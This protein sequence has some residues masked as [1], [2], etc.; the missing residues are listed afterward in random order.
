MTFEELRLAAPV[1]KALEREGYAEPTPIQTQA[2]PPLLDGRDILAIA[3][4]G[5]GKTAAFALPILHRLAVDPQAPPKRGCRALVLSP[6]RELAAQI[7]ESFRVYGRF[8]ELS[9]AVVVGGVD[10]RKQIKKLV[11]GVDVLVATPG[12]LIDH[13]EQGTVRLGDTQVFVLD[14]ADQMLDMGFVR[15]IRRIAGDLPKQRQNLFFSATM[16]KEIAGLA[17]ELLTDPVK[18][19][20]TP[21]ATTAER[22]EQRIIHVDAGRK[23][24]LLA[25]LFANPEMQRSL[26]FTRTKRGAD[27]V[28]KHLE[29]SGVSAAAIH[30]NK[31]QSQRTKALNAFRDASVRVLVATDI[32][33]RGIDID[34]VTHVVNYELPEVPEAYVHRIGRTARAGASG[35]AISLCDA[36][37]REL[38]RGIEKL[39][40]QSIPS[41]SRVG[42]DSLEVTSVPPRNPPG[43]GSRNARGAAGARQGRGGAGRRPYRD[44]DADEAPV[45]RSPVTGQPVRSGSNATN[46]ATEGSRSD[47]PKRDRS[48][49][50]ERGGYREGG[51][52]SA[53][54]GH[55]KGQGRRDRV[56][57]PGGSRDAEAFGGARRVRERDASER[58]NGSSNGDRSAHRGHRKGNGPNGP[59]RNGSARDGSAHTGAEG[60]ERG[61]HRKQAGGEGTGRQRRDERTARRQGSGDRRDRS[62]NGGDRAGS[63]SRRPSRPM[64]G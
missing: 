12:R 14:E 32:A 60:A 51:E 61:G 56:G 33:A 37:E 30:G 59:S 53:K 20:V 8:L 38:L 54:G 26:V 57:A 4:T 34:D 64:A 1:L 55:R 62:Q 25:E 11:A 16:P 41:E 5:T 50:Q 44:Y 24:A 22:V 21:V 28:A 15:P 35:Q 10:F 42:D 18:I 36:D 48:E 45:A 63:R 40:R 7:A 19:A 31:S 3:Q 13:V 6:T 52:R 17:A 27:R 43:R 58:T 2:I 29:S 49:R 46:G 39:T 23:R 9:I 47:R